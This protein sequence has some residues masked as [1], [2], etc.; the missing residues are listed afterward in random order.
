[1]R[2][3]ITFPAGILQFPFF[4]FDAD[5]AVNYGGIGAVI[6]HEITHGF[7]DQGRKFDADGN[8]KD[9]WTEEDAQQFKLRADK[10]VELYN[11]FKVLDTLHLNGKLTLGENIADLGG[12]N[13]ATRH[14]RKTRQGNQIKD[15]WLY[16]DQ[17]FFWMGQV[18]RSTPTGTAANWYG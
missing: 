14:L 2:N 9:W 18:W 12:L 4:D 17:R 11:G 1:M 3:E 15:R 10:V 8:L 6:G 7:D 16:D 13:M 5:D